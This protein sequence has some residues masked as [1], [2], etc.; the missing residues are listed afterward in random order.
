MCRRSGC[1]SEKASRTV[2]PERLLLRFQ[3]TSAILLSG[4][5]A[6]L[7]LRLMP[8]ILLFRLTGPPADPYRHANGLR[9][10]LFDCLDRLPGSVAAAV[11]E[12]LRRNQPEVSR[13]MEP[14]ASLGTV[15]HNLQ[16]LNPV[17]LGPLFP[18]PEG[19]LALR[20]GIVAEELIHPLIALLYATP[21]IRLGTA[22]YRLELPGT[23][24]A[25]RSYAD[26]MAPALSRPMDVTFE[27]P[28]AFHY[29]PMGGAQSPW[30]YRLLRTVF[31]ESA[32]VAFS[33]KRPGGERD[34][35]KTL[36]WPDPDR[37]FFHWLSKWRLYSEA[38]LREDLP[39]WVNRHVGVSAYEG[40]TVRPELRE[41]G[42]GAAGLK[43]PF[44][45][46]IGQVEFS[47]LRV[48]EVPEE[49]KRELWALARFATYCGT[50]VDT[51]RGMGQTIGPLD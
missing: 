24:E 46:F 22:H 21:E 15:F 30:P 20:L 3:E 17:T 34:A 47:L 31:G 5:P 27:S 37:C 32:E 49:V 12:R 1:G 38:P 4:S 42:K 25:P 41:E 7:Y 40:R 13:L 51:I 18:H 23:I 45:G 39:R 2:A 28:M 44:I 36:P 35:R 16:R 50:G 9:A 33:G 48:K 14:G 29:Q 6:A 19:G 11:V 26:L 8:A 10:L 43:R